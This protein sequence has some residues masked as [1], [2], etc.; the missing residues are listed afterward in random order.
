MFGMS[1]EQIEELVTRAREWDWADKETLAMAS[2]RQG[3]KVAKALGFTI[4]LDYD[5]ESHA[6]LHTDEVSVLEPEDAS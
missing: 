1:D 5:H 3:F 6:E 2:I 4:H